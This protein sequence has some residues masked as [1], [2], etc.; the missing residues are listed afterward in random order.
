M[1]A[2]DARMNA[3]DCRT[4]RL[5][6]LGGRAAKAASTPQIVAVDDLH[7][8]LVVDFNL[9]TLVAV[10]RDPGTRWAACARADRREAVRLVA[11]DPTSS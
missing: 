7:C 6:V 11:R 3:S 10:G 8:G 4:I 2:R 1:A 5:P 9:P